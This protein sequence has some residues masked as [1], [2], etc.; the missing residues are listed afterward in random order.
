MKKRANQKKLIIV[1]LIVIILFVLGAVVGRNTT[2]FVDCEKSENDNGWLCDS[3]FYANEKSFYP[4]RI[5]KLK[6]YELKLKCLSEG[7]EVDKFFHTDPDFSGTF[8]KCLVPYSDAG[9]TC[10]NSD[11][12]QGNC[13]YENGLIN[14][15]EECVKGE[16][17]DGQFFYTCPKKILG[18]CTEKTMSNDGCF[19]DVWSEVADNIIY[20]YQ[21][22]NCLF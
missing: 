21:G 3:S 12:C 16:A 2:S 14:I 9:Q 5:S 19:A 13:K 6:L 15:P 22:S 17:S 7:G 18:A 10:S 8:F 1:I 11:E 20:S 4:Q